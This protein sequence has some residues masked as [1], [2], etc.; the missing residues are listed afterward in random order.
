MFSLYVVPEAPG[1]MGEIISYVESFYTHIQNARRFPDRYSNRIKNAIA[2]G[3][4]PKELELSAED[5]INEIDQ[6]DF[7]EQISQEEKERIF[8]P[9][10]EAMKS[11]ATQHSITLPDSLIQRI[12]ILDGN[13]TSLICDVFGPFRDRNIN[14]NFTIPSNR[15]SFINNDLATQISAGTGMRKEDLIREFGIHEL[16]HSAAYTEIWLVNNDPLSEFNLLRRCGIFTSSLRKPRYGFSP[17]LEGFT[18]YLTRETLRLLNKP[19]T[20]ALDYKEEL[21]IIDILIE[22]IG[23]GP[24]IRA[25]FSKRGFR[26]L[27]NALEQR[28]GKSAFVKIN[29]ELGKELGNKDNAPASRYPITKKFLQESLTN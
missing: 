10:I 14:I 8:N 5:T 23:L 6:L 24:F 20:S 21:E 16:W 3:V 29:D 26:I 17:L 2:K 4:F 1:S 22:Q 25:A 28:F 7:Q 13:T 27:F 9:A 19:L 15:L 12:K 18:Q 11:F